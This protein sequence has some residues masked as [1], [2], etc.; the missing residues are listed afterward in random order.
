M[1][2]FK[3]IVISLW[4]LISCSVVVTAQVQKPTLIIMQFFGDASIDSAIV[5]Q[6]NEIFESNI[7]T[8]NIFSIKDRE[9]VIAWL[10]QNGA[11]PE[12]LSQDDIVTL[13][14]NCKADFIITGSLTLTKNNDYTVN[15]RVIAADTGR[16]VYAKPITF[17]SNNMLDSL[18]ELATRIVV[19]V[20]QRTDV[21][22]AQIDVLVQIKDWQAALQYLEIYER[23][24]PDEIQKTRAYQTAIYKALGEKAFNDAKR[25]LELNLFESA[26][27]S[28]GLALKYEPDNISYKEFSNIIEQQYALMRQKTEEDI[29]KKL[30]ELRIREQWEAGLALIDYLES[31]GSKNPKIALYK[32]EFANKKQARLY[33]IEA[34]SAYLAGDF[35]GSLLNIERALE[36]YPDNETYKKFRKKVFD[37]AQR[38]N[39]SRAKWSQ[40]MEEARSFSVTEKF[41]LYRPNDAN[42]FVV[43]DF[44]IVTIMPAQNLNIPV[45]SE[46]A[47][48]LKP[49][50]GCGAW[51]QSKFIN[52]YSLMSFMSVNA[53][54]YSGITTGYALAEQAQ[55][56]QYSGTYYTLYQLGMYYFDVFGGVEA[57]LTAF[58][59]LVSLGL[60]LA[61]SIY[62]ISY[63]KT[64]PF[65]KT[66]EQQSVTEASFNG[67]YRIL[68]AWNISEKSQLFVIL[69]QRIPLH[70]IT[71][72][73]FVG[74]K[75][76]SISAGYSFMVGK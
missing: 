47:L 21:T 36:L 33:Y 23:I 4:L 48:Q 45:D 22:L 67:G 66:T 59:F 52:E 64:V 38:E 24:H 76:L 6:I 10:K 40:Y 57:S 30:D 28:I 61:T 49:Q 31:S 71:E 63:Q 26:R 11:L 46:G 39:E 5:K 34:H 17:S 7:I 9:S 14:R 12:K 68:V 41:L 37:L 58:S 62:S 55:E 53:G 3:Q 74:F 72:N 25:A 1:R 15:P 18:L 32:E 27:N 73:L 50:F 20:R 70:S 8:T 69:S 13:A 29:F 44:P 75:K 16:E 56:A 42:V 60:E 54:W 2:S 19:A 65:L 35:S 43:L 51:Y